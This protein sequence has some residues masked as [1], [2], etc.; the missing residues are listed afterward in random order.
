MAEALKSMD[1][2]MKTM[3]D[4][5]CKLLSLAKTF[6]ETADRF[7]RTDCIKPQESVEETKSGAK[8]SQKATSSKSVAKRGPAS[9]A[10]ESRSEVMKSVND[11]FAG[12]PQIRA[13]LGTFVQQLESL[14]R[15]AAELS[16]KYNAK[17]PHV[18]PS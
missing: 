16:S 7:F 3:E 2:R 5:I 17:Q 1:D 15:E 18:H 9:K 14:Q 13:M 11:L 6:V 12:H 10:E 8:K 4:G